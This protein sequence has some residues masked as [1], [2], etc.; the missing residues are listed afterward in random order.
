LE[1]CICSRW[2]P[3]TCWRQWRR[4]TRTSQCR[5]G[6]GR[7]TISSQP[8]RYTRCRGAG[9]C[10]S[11]ATELQQHAPQLVCCITPLMHSA[12]ACLEC[13]HVY[14][15]A[16]RRI[17]HANSVGIK[18]DKIVDTNYILLHI[19]SCTGARNMVTVVAITLWQHCR[20]RI[21]WCILKNAGQQQK[22][23]V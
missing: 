4:A 9:I 17:S 19:S 5:G 13:M 2:P 22:G 15:Y 10:C 20:P 8:T 3:C 7:S 6:S 14:L 12:R 23:K 18:S 11:P 1:P 16:F 21:D